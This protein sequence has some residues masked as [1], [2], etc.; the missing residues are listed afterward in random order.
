M[1]DCSFITG[2]NVAI[3]FNDPDF[4]AEFLSLFIH[5]ITRGYFL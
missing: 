1:R 4:Q 5:S 2:L 3:R